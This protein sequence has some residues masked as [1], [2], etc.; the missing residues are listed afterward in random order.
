MPIVALTPLIVVPFAYFIEHERPGA[1]S[2]AGGAV[3][4]AATAALAYF[5]HG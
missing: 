1:R 4:V 3:A 2:L 5:R